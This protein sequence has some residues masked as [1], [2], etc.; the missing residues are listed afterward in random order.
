M[1]LGRLILGM[2]CF[3]A[4][5]LAQAQSDG[6]QDQRETAAAFYFWGT[7]VGG[8]TVSGSEVEVEFSDIVDNLEAGFMGTFTTRKNDWSFMTDVIY[9]NVAAS[10][11]AELS[12]PI[13]PIQVPVTTS[14]DLDMTGWI[15]HFS[16]GYELFSDGD[17][18][19]DVIGGLSYLDLDTELFLE[20]ASLGPG[21]SRTITDAVTAWDAIIGLKG[22]TSLGERWSLPY[23]VDIGTG[24]SSFTWQA[25]LG[26]AFQAGSRWDLALLYRHLEWDVDA[27]SVI[28]EISYSGPMLGARFRF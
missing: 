4:P 19:L 5:V 14:T 27:T 21:Q 17:S 6:S 3:A 1:Q 28:D 23:Y 15:L 16:G 25:A 8:Q 2:I 13:G 10:E 24:Q 7:D 20:L 18:R 22:R 12:I 26:V 11:T 9:F